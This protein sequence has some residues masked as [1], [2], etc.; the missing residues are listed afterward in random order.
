MAAV[1][2]CDVCQE[3]ILIALSGE[4]LAMSGG[5]EEAT[6]T[7]RG[8]V[9]SKCVGCKKNI[10]QDPAAAKGHAYFPETKSW[11]NFLAS[12]MKNGQAVSFK[13]GY[14]GDLI[15][16]AMRDSSPVETVGVCV[17][18]YITKYDFYEDAEKRINY[19]YKIE[20]ENGNLKTVTF[21]YSWSD[22]E[23][24]GGHVIGSY[25]GEE[26]A[27]LPF[28]MSNPS[29]NEY[30]WSSTFAYFFDNGTLRWNEG[31][32]DNCQSHA[33]AVFKCEK[34]NEKIVISVSGEHYFD[35]QRVTKPTETIEGKV[36]EHCAYCDKWFENCSDKASGKK[37]E[38]E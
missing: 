21:E 11:N 29:L 3:K 22:V 16:L 38:G 33:L 31:K 4:H 34:C 26:V 28:L 18:T 17:V 9:V 14:C 8:A 27:A 25:N 36:E 2:T 12:D 1:F 15:T 19:S 24:V 37:K 30:E 6:C 10:E 7:K 20:D 13:C 32:P 5:D 35:K 23:I